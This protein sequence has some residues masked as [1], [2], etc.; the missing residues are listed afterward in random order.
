MMLASHDLPTLANDD[1]VARALLDMLFPP[2]RLRFER[3]V[4]QRAARRA[5]PAARNLSP[6]FDAHCCPDHV[7]VIDRL[8]SGSIT[9]TWSD[10]RFGKYTEQI[11]HAA[12]AHEHAV[13]ALTGR[14]IAQGSR[15]FRPRKRD[16]NVPAEYPWMILSSA[17]DTGIEL[18]VENAPR[19]HAPA[20]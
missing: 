9:V 4:R 18:P 12:L 15:V 10:S 17:L 16:A 3:P 8:P 14:E 20:D 7:A 2:A 6:S 11:W 19:R 5:A 1:I 13:C